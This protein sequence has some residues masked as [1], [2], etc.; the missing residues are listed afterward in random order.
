MFQKKDIQLC[1]LDCGGVVYPYSLD[2][3]Y[4]QVSKYNLKEDSL[5][6]KWKELMLGKISVSDFNKDVCS[7]CGVCYD[8]QKEAELNFSLL[9]GVGKIYPQ[10]RELIAYL[11]G[12]NLKIGLLSN[13]LPQL[14]CTIGEL[15]LDKEFIFPSYHLKDLKP[16]ASIFKKVQERTQIPFHKMLFIDD[17]SENVEVALS[18]GIKSLVY[19]PKTV[20]NDIKRIVGEKNVRCSCNRRC[21]CR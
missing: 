14:E 19:N 15:C 21:N 1:L 13:A 10:T 20:L 4:A 18:F 2:Y 12:K 11:K 3:F 8:S 7:L 6:F 17:K 16:N 9:K 5:H